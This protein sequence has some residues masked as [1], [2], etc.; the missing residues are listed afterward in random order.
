MAIGPEPLREETISVNNGIMSQH[1]MD[2]LYRAGNA[3]NPDGSVLPHDWEERKDWEKRRSELKDSLGIDLGEDRK[4][5][6]KWEKE[7]RKK[8]VERKRLVGWGN[9]R[10]DE[11]ARVLRC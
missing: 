3:W 4:A 5:V 11:M 2:A 7:D 10:P 9:R 1:Q 8:E 6:E